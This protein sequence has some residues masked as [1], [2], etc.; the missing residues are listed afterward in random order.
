VYEDGKKA[1]IVHVADVIRQHARPGQPVIGPEPIITTYLSDRPVWGLNTFL[2]KRAGTWGRVLSQLKFEL[3]VFPAGKPAAMYE[4]D[5]AT[6]ALIAAHMLLPGREVGRT[7]EGTQLCEVRVR[8]SR[9]KSTKGI[10]LA[11]RRR[12]AAEAAT[13]PATQPAT[14]K[15]AP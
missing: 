4:K 1:P 11:E 10:R 6:P 15:P 2:P 7:V 5:D 13:R 12:A 3:A 8:A 14:T 9:H